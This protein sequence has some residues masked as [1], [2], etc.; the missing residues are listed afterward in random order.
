MALPTLAFQRRLDSSSG[1]LAELEETQEPECQKEKQREQSERESAEKGE[2]ADSPTQGWLL[3]ISCGP[4]ADSPPP[5]APGLQKELERAGER[6]QCRRGARGKER[7]L[8]AGERG[9]G[10]K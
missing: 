1:E 7:V 2:R 10:L 5:P 3:R 8:A 6:R 4:A 9:Q